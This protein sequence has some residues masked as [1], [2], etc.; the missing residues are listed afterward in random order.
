MSVDEWLEID[1]SA[2]T[3]PFPLRASPLSPVATHQWDNAAETQETAVSAAAGS[4]VSGGVH[5]V[6]LK[7]TSDPLGSTPVQNVEDVHEIPEMLVVSTFAGADQLEP[8][9]RTTRPA[10]SP[11]AQKLAVG[12]DTEL[13]PTL[14]TDLGLAHVA[15]WSTTTRPT[16]S[17]ATQNLVEGHETAVSA[18][19]LSMVLG[20][21]Q[22]DAFSTMALPLES[23]P[24]QKLTEAHETASGTPAG[25]SMVA[26]EDHL[27][28]RTE[29]GAA[30]SA[31]D[32]NKPTKAGPPPTSAVAAKSTAMK[33][34]F[35]PCTMTEG[36]VVIVLLGTPG[37][38]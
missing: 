33:L 14:S 28:F 22:R 19:P 9:S 8:W 24:T 23:T 25:C 7:I 16:V 13:N 15:L 6:P 21:D 32:A 2:H 27:T 20:S 37:E 26:D 11:A 29:R 12:Q 5:V 30:N 38:A 4:T 10:S 31:R 35:R 34:C 17:T 3:D 1:V 18:V 36:A